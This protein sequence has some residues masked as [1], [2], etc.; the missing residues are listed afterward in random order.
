MER[1]TLAVKTNLIQG[2]DRELWKAVQKRSFE[3]PPL[4]KV[5]SFDEQEASSGDSGH[6]HVRLP[7]HRSK[8]CSQ[9]AEVSPHS[10]HEPSPGVTP[11]SETGSQ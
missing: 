11:K 8:L 4:S 5:A 1:I 9:A 10:D 6:V 2:L 7:V 3:I